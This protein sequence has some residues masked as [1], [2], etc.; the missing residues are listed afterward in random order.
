MFKGRNCAMSVL[1]N[2]LVFFRLNVIK[3]VAQNEDYRVFQVL[4]RGKNFSER[5]PRDGSIGG[6]SHNL[7][8]IGQQIH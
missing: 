5:L 1:M 4:L 7:R 8:C 6:P 2:E 3:L